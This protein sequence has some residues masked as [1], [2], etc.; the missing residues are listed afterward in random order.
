MRRSLLIHLALFVVVH[1]VISLAVHADIAFPSWPAWAWFQE[2]VQSGKSGFYHEPTGI[3]ING[4]WLIILILD[5]V[6]SISG[7]QDPGNAGA[8]PVSESLMPAKQETAVTRTEPARSV[9]ERRYNPWFYMIVGGM[10]E[11]VWAALLKLNMLGGPLL[12]IFYFSFYC[13]AKA[14]KSLPVSTVAAAFAGIG[15]AGTVTMDML[16]FESGVSWIRIGFV[17]LLTGFIVLLKISGDAKK[18]A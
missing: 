15:A 11:I 17:M 13:L 6:F 7:K 18:G 2:T 9:P 12:L 10:L 16:F 3:Y 14:A 1:V 4:L 8:P 5:A